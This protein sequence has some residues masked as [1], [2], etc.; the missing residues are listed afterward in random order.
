MFCLSRTYNGN[1][2][3][4]KWSSFQEWYLVLGV[5]QYIDFSFNTSVG[6]RWGL[7]TVAGAIHMVLWWIKRGISSSGRSNIYVRTSSEC[8][9]TTTSITVDTNTEVFQMNLLS[10]RILLPYLGGAAISGCVLIMLENI[11]VTLK[12]A[13]LLGFWG[14]F[15]ET[16]W[17]YP[18]EIATIS[19]GVKT[20]K[21]L[22]VPGRLL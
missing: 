5:T 13:K 18:H 12:W 4:Q 6:S 21:Y 3:L 22:I 10:S 8:K 14:I 7:I 2:E 1:W 19:I 16:S 11:F 20:K 15:S 9:V 17:V